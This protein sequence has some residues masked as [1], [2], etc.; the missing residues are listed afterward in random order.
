MGAPAR[1]SP[2]VTSGLQVGLD[3]L[4]SV[5]GCCRAPMLRLQFDKAREFLDKNAE[6]AFDVNR[7]EVEGHCT[8]W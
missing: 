1:D 4:T 6:L 7:R 8:E 3:G 5:T 2:N